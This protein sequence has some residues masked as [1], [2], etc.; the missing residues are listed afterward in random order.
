MA[1]WQIEGFLDEFGRWKNQMPA[2]SLD[3]QRRVVR[4]VLNDLASDPFPPGAVPLGDE[5]DVT[6]WFVPLPFGSAPDRR[7][8]CIYRIN[9]VDHV[10]TCHNLSELRLPI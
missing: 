7:V 5:F 1:R 9:D 2:P 4:W 3:L 6:W 8:T 10:L